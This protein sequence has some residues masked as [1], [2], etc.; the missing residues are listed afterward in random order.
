MDEKKITGSQK[1]YGRGYHDAMRALGLDSM[2]QAKLDEAIKGLTGIAR[3]VLDVVPIQEYWSMPQIVSEIGRLGSRPDHNVVR[4]C[5]RSL[6]D[7]GL[8]KRKGPTEKEVYCK[9]TAKPADEHVKSTPEIFVNPQ[10]TRVIEMPHPASNKD[11]LG[12]LAALSADA[13]LIS[14]R[15]LSLARSLDDLAIEVEERIQSAAQGSEKLKQ[16]QD[17]LRSI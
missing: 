10:A 5:L 13:R 7:Q 6:S 15:L 9:V 3:K 17:L 16:L 2:K 12:K 14:D 8:I 4:G 11:T 1:A